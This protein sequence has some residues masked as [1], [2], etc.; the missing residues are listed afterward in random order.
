ML[1]RSSS[2]IRI[3]VIYNQLIYADEKSKAKKGA[4]G[5][6]RRG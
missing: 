1:S 2:V 4:G 3:S 6:K 5:K